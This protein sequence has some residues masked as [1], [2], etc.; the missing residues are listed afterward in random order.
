MSRPAPTQ[1]SSRSPLFVRLIDAAPDAAMAA[2]FYIAWSNPTALGEQSVKNLM[3]VMLLEFIVVH[4]AAF[5]GVAHMKATSP[6]MKVRNMIGLGLCYSLF[7][8]GFC[9]GF[10]TWW[11]MGLF[12][13]LVVNRLAV[14]ILTPMPDAQRRL[15]IQSGW[16]AG[17]AFYLLS[18]FAGLGPWPAWGVTPQVITAQDF[19]D[20]GGIWIERPQTVMV[21]GLIYFTLWAIYD[22]IGGIWF[23][24]AKP[25]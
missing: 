1:P 2:T 3:L 16:G 10:E 8:L 13:L 23:K 22:L 9:L 15:R 20:T 6:W 14:A 11:P 25:I 5:M 18:V 12:W 19:G 24:L 21:S 7:V 4:S 17:A